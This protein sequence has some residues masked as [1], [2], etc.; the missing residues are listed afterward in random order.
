MHA[1]A[2]RSVAIERAL[3]CIRIRVATSRFRLVEN[4][5]VVMMRKLPHEKR[6]RAH[7]WLRYLR[8]SLKVI[9]NWIKVSCRAY[10]LLIKRR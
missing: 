8:V 7:R 3:E 9:L 1:T 4:V 5:E 10:L 2:E 6:K